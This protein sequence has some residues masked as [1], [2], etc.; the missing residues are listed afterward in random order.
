[1][2]QLLG[3]DEMRD[4]LEE[5]AEPLLDQAK[6]TAPVLSGDYRDGLHLEV[7]KV[8]GEWQVRIAG[9]T[10]HDVAVEARTGNLARALDG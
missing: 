4:G 3:T 5:M 8:H 6:S 1:V 2:D 10:G 9:S 7:D